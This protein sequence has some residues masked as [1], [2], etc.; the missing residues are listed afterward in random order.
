VDVAAG[1]GEALG[2]QPQRLT[3]D[4]EPGAITSFASTSP[5]EVS[6]AS[7]TRAR[8]I[9]DAGCTPVVV[10]RINSSRSR[11]VN[12]TGRFFCEGTT[13][14]L[15]RSHSVGR[16]LPVGSNHGA[17]PA[18]PVMGRP[19]ARCSARSAVVARLRS[20]HD[21]HRKGRLIGLSSIEQSRCVSTR[22]R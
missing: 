14:V 9:V 4:P 12:V 13:T 20:V 11:A 2:D 16:R 21:F 5:T 8:M 18:T 10:N 22:V 15:V 6:S 7:S 19:L 3:R 17:L 1:L